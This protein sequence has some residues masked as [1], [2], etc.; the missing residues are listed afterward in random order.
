MVGGGS[1]HQIDITVNLT[2]PNNGPKDNKTEESGGEGC[3]R[4]DGDGEYM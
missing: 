2:A 4:G 3:W 1:M